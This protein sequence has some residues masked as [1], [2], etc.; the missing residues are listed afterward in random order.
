M[1]LLAEALGL[2]NHPVVVFLTLT[3][4][5][6]LYFLTL[7]SISYG[8]FFVW[9]RDRFHPGYQPDRD[10]IKNS[11]KWSFY[12]VSGNAALM[13]PVH[14]L[15]AGG[16]SKIYWNVGDHGWGWMAAQVVLILAITET[17]IYW[18]HRW[19]HSD[20]LYHHIHKPHH[21]FVVPTPWAGVAFNPLDSF[22]QALPHHLCLF[23]F[24]V[25]GGVYLTFIGFITLWAVMIHDRLSFMPW[26]GVNY[27]GHH[28]LHHWYYNCNYGQFFTLWDRLG[29]TYRD[30]E[31]APDVPV[32]VL[33]PH[34]LRRP[35]ARETEA[36]P[37]E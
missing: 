28:T 23:L 20:W 34:I 16:Y 18:I 31:N 17:L 32:E 21:Q 14:L 6:F 3:I 12:S 11:L 8:I 10:D 1:G 15:I 13:M 5:G 4:G 26:R 35:P 24:P 30:P 19:L 37:A 7:A 33:R 2:P 27:T 22:A 29:G 36:A 25:H 9:K